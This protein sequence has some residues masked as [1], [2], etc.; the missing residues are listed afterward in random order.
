MKRGF[1]L[2]LLIIINFNLISCVSLSPQAR[3]VQAHRVLADKLASN[4]L[5][6]N[7]ESKGCTYI[8]DVSGDYI[9]FDNEDLAALKNKAANVGGNLLLVPDELN[10]QKF[11]LKTN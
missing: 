5:K 1:V 10:M 6:Q 2:S 11:F 4:S 3:K 9:T 8:D 7:L